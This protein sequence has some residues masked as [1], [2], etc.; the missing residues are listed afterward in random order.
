MTTITE[1]YTKW[2]DP[3]KPGDPVKFDPFKKW[4]DPSKTAEQI[5]EDEAKAAAPPGLLTTIP[6]LWKDGTEQYGLLDKNLEGAFLIAELA[7]ITKLPHAQVLM[8]LIAAVLYVILVAADV[9]GGFLT[10]ILAIGWPV[11]Q[12]L[13]AVEAKEAK[14]LKLECVQQW[15]S[16]WIILALLSL[17]EHGGKSLLNLIP[18]YYAF[19]LVFLLWLMIPYSNG[20]YVIY[21]LVLKNILPP[22]KTEE[23]P[24]KKEEP[25]EVSKWAYFK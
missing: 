22:I 19:K 21:S 10:Y 20:A 5:K 15:V 8:Y 14:D 11:M 2:R 23:T 17:M 24:S 9:Y 4:R 25:V 3:P 13:R 16:Y 18:F 1:T 12:S 6:Q 7:F